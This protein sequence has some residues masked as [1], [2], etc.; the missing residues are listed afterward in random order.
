MS[1]SVTVTPPPIVATT[2]PQIVPTAPDANAM[3]SIG[4]GGPLSIVIYHLTP[5]FFPWDTN[6]TVEVAT[7]YAT[8]ATYSV[9]ALQV[10]ILHFFG[11]KGQ[12]TNA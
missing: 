1:E 5:H 11:T 7:A 6:M 12:T 2:S 4:I 8:L 3:L 10:A 9:H